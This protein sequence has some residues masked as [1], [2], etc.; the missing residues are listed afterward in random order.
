MMHTSA[1]GASIPAA[2]QERKAL[3]GDWYDVTYERKASNNT[4]YPDDCALFLIYL[5]S[6]LLKKIK[7]PY[8]NAYNM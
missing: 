4:Q 2:S 1:T 3:A 8:K 6:I 7:E 5:D